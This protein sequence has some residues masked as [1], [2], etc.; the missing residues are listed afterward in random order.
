MVKYHYAT[1]TP[2][3]YLRQDLRPEENIGYIF[4]QGIP[5]GFPRAQCL[6]LSTTGDLKEVARN[7]YHALISMDERE[8]KSIYIEKP[9]PEGLGLTILDRLERATAK[10]N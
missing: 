3:H 4:I 9:L 2:L 1:Q 7:L 8:F 10:F 6:V 5:E